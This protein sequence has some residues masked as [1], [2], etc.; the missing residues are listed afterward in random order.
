MATV[1]PMPSVTASVLGG[2]DE[3]VWRQFVQH[4][5]L[6]N[7][8]KTITDFGTMPILLPLAFL[9]GLC[10]Y[11]RYRSVFLAV[12]PWCALQINSAVVGVLK[13]TLDI[14]R[15]PRVDWLAGAAGGSFPSGHTAN[16]TCLFVSL[17]AIAFFLEKRPDVQRSAV[18]I[19][20]VASVIM[21]WTR[22]ALNVHWLSD[23]LAGWFVGMFFG[24]ATVF[25]VLMFRRGSDKSHK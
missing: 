9:S 10:M 3:W 13:R 12:A 21:G 23:V 5:L 22:L 17:A 1:V 6:T 24:I 25:M 4:P 20:A 19:A 18:V 2:I 15:P 8:A 14:A 11:W 7:V 16:T